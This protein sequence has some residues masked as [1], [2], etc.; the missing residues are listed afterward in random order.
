M[1]LEMTNKIIIFML[2]FN[3]IFGMGSIFYSMDKNEEYDNNRLTNQIN[4]KLDKFDNDANDFNN[5][6]SDSDEDVGVWGSVTRTMGSAWK[7]SGFILKSLIMGLNPSK[8]ANEINNTTTNLELLIYSVINTFCILVNVLS[9][10]VLF[11]AIKK[12]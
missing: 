5:D 7:L 12:G 6:Y 8:F 10:V 9:L 11:F 4:T 1:T 3:I 2:V